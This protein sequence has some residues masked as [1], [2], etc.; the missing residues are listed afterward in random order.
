[1]RLS[2]RSYPH[3]VLGNRDDVPG[4]AFQAAVEVSMDQQSV[5][6]EVGT[7][8]S[9]ATLNELLV[10]GDAA[11]VVHVECSNT[12]YRKAFEFNESF[13]RTAIPIDSLNEAV[14]VNVFMRAVN[15]IPS[16][17]VPE[18]HPDYGESSFDVRRGDILAVAEGQIFQIE[19]N[20]DAL[21][22]IG[23][24][25]QINEASVEGD[26]PMEAVFDGDKIVIYLSKTD[27]ADYKSIKGNEAL[28]GPLTTAIV[29]PVLLEALHSLDDADGFSD[30]RRWV[31]ALTRRMDSLKLSDSMS[32]LEKAQRL[33]ELPMKR[34]LSLAR[35]VES[36]L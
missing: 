12:L 31:R 5:Y 36:N 30:P 17:R 34:A 4:A 28:A 6:I 14:E 15:R 21:G 8:C 9:C 16:Y 32:P 23:T 29:L 7:T 10:K 27:F 2:S 3:P 18:A 24:I 20:F 1:M 26:L 19:G 13:Y 22:R 25:M 35:G 33:L 11:L